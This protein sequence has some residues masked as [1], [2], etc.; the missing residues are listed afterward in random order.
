MA[1]YNRHI[2]LVAEAPP[3]V[4]ADGETVIST[5]HDAA[6]LTPEAALK[7]VRRLIEAAERLN[8]I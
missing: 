2:P 3:V 4:V 6:S 7:T 8:R 1:N 5:R